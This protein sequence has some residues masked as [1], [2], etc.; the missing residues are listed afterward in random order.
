VNRRF[1]VAGAAFL[2]V[3]AGG[4]AAD[5]WSDH[6][7]ARCEQR[8]DRFSASDLFA[9]RPGGYNPAGSPSAGCDIDRVAAYAS[10]QFLATNGGPSGDALSSGSTAPQVDRAAVTAFYRGLLGGDAWRFDV[11]TPAP[12]PNAAGLCADKDGTYVNVSFPMAGTY[13]LTVADKPDTS[14]NC[15]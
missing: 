8:G 3:A 12:G 11:R 13:E 4:Y 15:A 1:L 10:L 14:A 7:L 9:R 5:R 6:R 2:L